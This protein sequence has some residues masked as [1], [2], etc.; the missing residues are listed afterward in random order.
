MSEL[1]VGDVIH[2]LFGPFLARCEV[3]E[4]IEQGAR[5]EYVPDSV[6]YIGWGAALSAPDGAELTVSPDQGF[7]GRAH[8]DSAEVVSTA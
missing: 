7:L 4:I 6:Q 8:W 5:L 3:V 1:E 2:G